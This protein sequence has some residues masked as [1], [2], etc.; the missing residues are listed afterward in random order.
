MV[1][2]SLRQGELSV[3][4]LFSDTATAHGS[5]KSSWAS[6][7][8]SVPG[9]KGAGKRKNRLSNVPLLTPPL[10]LLPVP[11]PGIVSGSS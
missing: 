10:S 7:S 2:P 8:Y 9:K 3:K 11:V 5:L 1:V 4:P 6:K